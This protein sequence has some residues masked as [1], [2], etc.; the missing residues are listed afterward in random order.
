MI[1]NLIFKLEEYW[2]KVIENKLSVQLYSFILKIKSV[3]K[4]IKTL[5][6]K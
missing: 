1:E 5:K 2:K 4:S 6:N 3:N